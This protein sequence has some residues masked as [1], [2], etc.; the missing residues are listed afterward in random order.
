MIAP[1]ARQ[2]MPAARIWA[3]GLLV[4]VSAF[5][6]TKG[7]PREPAAGAEESCVGCH[8][9]LSEASETLADPA[10]RW[11]DDVHHAAGLSCTS[12]HGGDPSPSAAQ[13]GDKAMDPKRKGA[14]SLARVS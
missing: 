14:E 13:E 6:G 12:C 1:G 7:S 11:A 4:L 2:R 5:A 10:L 9:T 8:K 3:C